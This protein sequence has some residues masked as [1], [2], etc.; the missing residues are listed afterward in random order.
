MKL[1]N[2][3][4][5][6]LTILV[7]FL[8]SLWAVLFYF[9]ITHEITDETDDM[10]RSYRDV[11]VKRALQHPQMLDYSED[12]VFDR[13]FIREIT[14]AEAEDYEESFSDR[15]IYFPEGN[16]TI[17]TRIYKSIFRASDQRYYELEIEM[18]T[19]ERDDML[20]TLIVYL[21]VLFFLLLV[22][23][24]VGNRII[25]NRSLKPLGRLLRWLDTIVPGKPVP[26]LNNETNI[27]EFARLNEASLDFSRRSL[28]VYEQQ[29]HFIENVSH[30][31]QTPLAIALNKIELLSQ[32][33]DV[34]ER[35]L[36]EMAEVQNTLSRAVK[37]NKSLLFLSRIE[38][39]QFQDKK[40]VDVGN[41]A[42]GLLRDFEEIYSYKQLH[43][44]ISKKSTLSVSMNETLAQI[45]LTNLLKNAFVYT[46]SEGRINI[47]MEQNEFIIKNSGSKPL[48]EN[49]VFTRFYR[50]PDNHNNSTGLGLAIVKSIAD[51]NS[52]RLSYFYKD[53]EHV[54]VLKFVK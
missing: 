1:I 30:E 43:I 9:A 36:S 8:I 28:R 7:L 19:V 53:S 26:E 11:F 13:Y 50:M 45:M 16:E 10:L 47:E 33:E 14:E 48:D 25:L 49:K 5:N 27:T 20:E 4:N 32:D 51:L 17:P 39:E 34:T 12:A 18:S 3:I 31:L 42:D 22:S 35:Q 52:I 46:P 54:F 21:S 40:V 37:L 23:F 6:K 24:V 15:E 38:N 44:D 2:Y 41:M 29:R